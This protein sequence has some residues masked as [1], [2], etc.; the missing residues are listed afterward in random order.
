MPSRFAHSRRVGYG[1]DTGVAS[2]RHAFTIRG[3]II[4]R[5]TGTTAG[6]L[7]A[8]F[9][10]AGTLAADFAAADMSAA[11]LAAA[12]VIAADTDSG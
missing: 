8:D 6:T 12:A 9:A 4:I 11:D 7:A 3:P 10:A 2:I 5:I 1:A